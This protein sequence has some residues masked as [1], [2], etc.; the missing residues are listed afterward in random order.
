MLACTT[1]SDLDRTDRH[2]CSFRIHR[3]G[4]EER[5]FTLIELLVVMILITIL[6]AIALAVFLRQQ[7][8]ARDADAKSNVTNLVREVQACNAGRPDKEDFRDCDTAGK[9]GPTDLPIS[10]DAPAEISSGDCDDPPESVGVTGPG[11]VRIA[12]AGPDCFVVLGV[13]DSGNRFWYVKRND[14]L[15]RRDCTTHGVNGCPSDGSWAG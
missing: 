5:G 6:A 8:K 3:R 7:D 10:A 1:G 12:E 4:A 11:A 15:F 9:L 2:H 14:G 13:S